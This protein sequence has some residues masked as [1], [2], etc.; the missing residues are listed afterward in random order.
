MVLQYL[1][2]YFLPKVFIV[3]PPQLKKVGTENKRATTW[4][5]CLAAAFLTCA[6]S[7]AFPEVTE[8]KGSGT[9]LRKSNG[10]D[11]H[12]DLNVWCKAGGR[13]W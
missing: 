1:A 4:G 2:I 8:H 10:Q 5:N 3:Y 7:Q 11:C 9:K 13:Q 12:M 6:A